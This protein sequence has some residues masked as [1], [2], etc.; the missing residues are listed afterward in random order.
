LES[1]RS[2]FSNTA[3]HFEICGTIEQKRR[4][5]IRMSESVINQPVDFGQRSFFEAQKNIKQNREQQSS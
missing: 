5:P 4:L 2:N 1:L 3:K